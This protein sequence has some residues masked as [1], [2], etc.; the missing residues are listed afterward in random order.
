MGFFLT[1][2]IKE[3]SNFIENFAPKKIAW[4][5]DNIGFQVGNPN[6]NLKNILLALDLKDDVVSS[7]KKLNCN[8]IVTHHPLIFQPLKSVL[9]NSFP[10]NLISKLLKNK[11]TLYTA[12]TNLDFTNC[13]VNFALAKKLELENIKSFIPFKHKL[14]K[15]VVFVPIEYVEKVMNTMAKFGAG[16]ISNYENCSF[17][18][19]GVGTFQGNKNTNPFAG[20]KNKLEKVNEIRIE[21]I[22]FEWNVEKIISAMI[23]AHPY[24]EVAYDIYPLENTIPNYGIGTTGELKKSLSKIEF[25]KFVKNKLNTKHLKYSNGKSNVIKKI[26]LVSGSGSEFLQTAIQ[27]SFDAFI[28]SDISY[29]KFHDAENKILLVD[30][31]HFETE[32]IILN[33]LKKFLKKNLHQNNKIFIYKNSTSAIEWF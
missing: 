24:E 22:A 16:K 15:I 4:E 32:V 30:A 9:E 25:L 29:H 21:M 13:G 11:I 20:E 33:N 7:A 10:G 14:K 17:Q 1:M 26:A 3:V 31:G 28:T 5:K 6:E 12:H 8:L 27:N 23:D 19:Q 2:K 18:T